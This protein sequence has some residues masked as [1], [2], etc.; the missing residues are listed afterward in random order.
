MGKTA[1]QS[2]HVEESPL[3]L[4]RGELSGAGR[5]R[6]YL[7]VLDMRQRE[8]EAHIASGHE[9]IFQGLNDTCRLAAW[10]S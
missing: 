8:S 3:Q 2:T 6:R 9:L 1:S 7:D 10:K 4:V 5:E